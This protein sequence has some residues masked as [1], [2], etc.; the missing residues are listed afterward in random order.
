MVEDRAGILDFKLGD[1]FQDA[2]LLQKASEAAQK[3]L[4][5]DPRLE[6]KENQNLKE[7]L[8]NYI[9]QGLLETTL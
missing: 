7:H 2:K 4:K 5:T 9:R 6:F 8:Q 1:V 3:L